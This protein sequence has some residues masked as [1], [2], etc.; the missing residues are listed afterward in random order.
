[1]VSL[2]SSWLDGSAKIYEK[3]NPATVHT[4]IRHIYSCFKLFHIPYR[5]DSAMHRYSYAGDGYL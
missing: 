3:R 4:R 2:K 1:M 5:A